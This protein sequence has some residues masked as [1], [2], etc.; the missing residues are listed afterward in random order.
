MARYGCGIGW[1]VDYF[2][3]TYNIA[4]IDHLNREVLRVAVVVSGLYRSLL[5]WGFDLVSLIYD[6]NGRQL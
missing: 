2:S 1:I 5:S 4:S 3:V 6:G